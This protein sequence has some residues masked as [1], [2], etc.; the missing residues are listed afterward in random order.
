MF[1][2]S[3]PLV[4]DRYGGRRSR[5]RLPRW[6]VLLLCGTA[7]GATAVVLVQERYLPPRLSAS[8]SA[9]L[10]QGFEQANADRL[11][12]QRELGA[13]TTRLQAERAEK[14]SQSGALA[15]SLASAARAREDLASVIASLPPDPR[16]GGVEVRAGRFTAKGGMLAYDVVLTRERTTGK[17]MNG[18]MQLVVAGQPTRGGES[19]VNLQ[20]IALSLDGFE[21]V[22][23]SLPLPEGF[24]PR[25][26][27]IQ[28]LDRAAGKTLGTR[29]MLVK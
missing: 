7:V 24:K 20:P 16:G 13:A 2:R 18:L 25:Q 28:V 10:R 5:W 3:K 6:L 27:T 19:A 4:F 23:G 15:A 17:P 26:A 22:R 29:V 1:G 9:E 21:V 14:Q 12:L 11:R 8:E